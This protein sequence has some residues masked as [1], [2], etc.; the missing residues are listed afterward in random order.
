MSKIE[1]FSFTCHLC[2]KYR[3]DESLKFGENF[4][5]FMNSQED[6]GIVKIARGNFQCGMK[7]QNIECADRRN[8]GTREGCVG[9]RSL[10]G[11]ELR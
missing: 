1:I 9:Q 8:M 7:S 3:A 6:F 4:T 2:Q 11:V 10:R 5:L